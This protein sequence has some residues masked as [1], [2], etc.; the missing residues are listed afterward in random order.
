MARTT[1][2]IDDPVLR[3]LKRLQRRKGVSLG[4]LVSDLL[5]SAL[6]RAQSDVPAIPFVWHSQRM[7]A[8]VDLDD[9]AAVQ[10]ILDREF[11]EKLR[12]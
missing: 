1:L 3:D 11:I 8:I 9:K 4:R 12:R 5:A 2:D 10:A 6:A 7:G